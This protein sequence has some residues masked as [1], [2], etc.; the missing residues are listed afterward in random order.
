[1]ID[2][3][4]GSSAFEL[5]VAMVYVTIHLRRCLFRVFGII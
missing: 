2:I 3:V 4:D 1:M 5:P